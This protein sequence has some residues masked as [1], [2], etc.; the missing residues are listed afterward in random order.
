M[1][2]ENPK[3]AP[4]T[5][6]P[7][8]ASPPSKTPRSGRARLNCRWEPFSAIV[9]ELWPLLKRQDAE[10]GDDAL[11]LEPDWSRWFEYERAGILRIW[12]A[13]HERQLVGY[14]VC[15]VTNGLNCASVL[16]G[17]GVLFWLAPEWRDGLLGLRLLRSVELALKDLGVSV[18]RFNTNDLFEP[19]KSGR[20]RTGA[21]FTRA[22]F[23]AV[24][25]VYQKVLT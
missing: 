20:S 7:S 5:K 2:R 16:H 21:I 10:V 22:G 14:V 19:D 11:P 18:L 8:E 23:R 17:Y 12:A 9:D 24:E 1:R 25:T 4:S 6:A 15:L 13:R 3:A